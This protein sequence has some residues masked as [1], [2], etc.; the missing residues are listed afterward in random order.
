MRI[1]R[2]I[3]DLWYWIKCRLWYQ[4]NYVKIKT[5]SPTWHDRDCV[6]IHAMFQILDD[7]VTREKPDDAIDWDSTPRHRKARDKMDELLDWWR[8][9]YLKFDS[10]EGLEFDKIDLEDRF[11]PQKEGC[12]FIEMKPLS[13]NDSKCCQ[14]AWQREKQMEKDLTKKLKELIDI[15]RYLWV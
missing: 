14:I 12:S 7:F 15:R 8:N 5:L 3:H 2:K 10:H 13:E 6:L 4:Y 1:F 9:T 11:Y